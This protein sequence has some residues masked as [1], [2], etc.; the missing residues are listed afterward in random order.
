M[1]KLN[2]AT[3]I[4]DLTEMDFHN[5]VAAEDTNCTSLSNFNTIGE[6]ALY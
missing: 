2:A 5:S 3:V 4:L 6:C 1:Y